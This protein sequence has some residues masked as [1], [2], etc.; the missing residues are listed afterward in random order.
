MS[1]EAFDAWYEQYRQTVCM[2]YGAI[3][4][5]DTEALA[6]GYAA[7]AVGVGKLPC[8]YHASEQEA[9]DAALCDRSPRP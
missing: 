7:H 9:I 4:C 5:L 3:D 6:P 8:G 1:R 2:L